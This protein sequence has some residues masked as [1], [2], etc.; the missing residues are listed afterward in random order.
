MA[1]PFV[2]NVREALQHPGRQRRLELTGPLPGAG[3]VL[4]SARVPADAEV[5]VDVTVEAQGATV[6][7]QGTATAPWVGEC[8]RCLGA[9]GGT[10]EVELHEVFEESPVEGETYPLTGDQIDLAPVLAEAL[11]L[12]LPLAPLCRDDCVGPDPEAHPVG[13][14]EASEPATGDGSDEGDDREP[15]GDPRW[16]VLD[17]LRADR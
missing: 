14:S 4:Q 5:E 11:A 8:R 12:G 13:A 3:V 15:P 2:L 9:T 17:Q 10:V 6:I 7:V 1:R 16:A